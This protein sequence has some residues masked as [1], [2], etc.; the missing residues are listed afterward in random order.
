MASTC[1]DND[2]RWTFQIDLDQIVSERDGTNLSVPQEVRNSFL[3]DG[4]AI[5]PNVLTR[6]SV[7]MLN[8]R[9][10]EILRGRYDTHRKPD[11]TP[12]L[13]KNDNLLGFSGNLHNVKVLQVINVHKADT[14]FRKLAVDRCLAKT[15]AD[16][17]GWKGIRLAQDQVWAKPPGAQPLTFH[18]DTPYFM[19]Q[20]A[21]VVTVW[22]ALDD[23]DSELGPLEYVKGSH[24]WGDGR[25]GSS[26]QFFQSDGGQNLLRSAAE[27]EGIDAPEIVSVAGLQAGGISIHDGRTWHGS[28][29]NTSRT[30]PRRGLGLHFVPHDVRFTAEAS[31][32]RLWRSYVTDVDDLSNMDLPEEDFP[33]T[34][35][36]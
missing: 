28:G 22:V 18:R 5:F 24:R 14:M 32:S 8:D 33:V 23:M 4:F 20:P 15:V 6:S 30:K 25:V 17:T 35:P 34:W 1:T 31:T 36:A 9:L 10:E 19:F 11:K 12:P 2:C 29:K 27:R 16:L 26:N 13:L 7:G 21:D 3:E